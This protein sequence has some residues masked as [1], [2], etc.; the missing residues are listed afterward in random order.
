MGGK[1]KPMDV[2]LSVVEGGKHWTKAEIESRQ[3]QEIKLPKPK[4][5]TPPDW[6][7]QAGKKL[8]R[9]YAKM[10]LEFPAGMV[11]KLDTGTLARYCDCEIS[12]ANASNHK[13]VWLETATR[14][15][16][17][18]SE[19]AAVSASKDEIERFHD[20]YEAA[21]VQVDFWTNQM[22]KFEKMARSN[23]TEM[24]MTISKR[25]QLVAPKP[26]NPE[27]D[28]PLNALLQKYAE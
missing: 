9:K 1:R 20:A 22:V 13:N 7:S 8:F 5:L 14:R 15:L 12:Y 27:G 26:Q 11:S 28:D 25:C 17:A 4:A 6:L 21:K 23:A 10:L 24:G 3:E 2:N 16:Q 18:L 19:M